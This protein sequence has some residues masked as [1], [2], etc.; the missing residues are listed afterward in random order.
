VSEISFTNVI[1]KT[2]SSLLKNMGRNGSVS[3]I[4]SP[5]GAGL[6]KGHAEYPSGQVGKSLLLAGCEDK[7]SFQTKEVSLDN[8]ELKVASFT[9]T[10]HLI[11]STDIA[12]GTQRPSASLRLT[13][14]SA[15]RSA[16]L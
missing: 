9:R 11:T 10:A 1:T 14:Q 12:Q 5:N 13:H 6:E 2:L 4:T 8:G 15:P 16:S 7:V 3:N